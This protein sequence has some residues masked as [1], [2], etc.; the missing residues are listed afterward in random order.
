MTPNKCMEHVDSVKPNAY[1]EEDKL[2]WISE[3][4]GLVTRIVVQET[5]YDPYQYPDD[6]DTELL[7]PP[8][9]DVVYQL[10]LEAMIDFH[11][12]EYG[13]Y[14]NVM[15]MF[16]EKLDEYKKAYIREHMPESAGNYTMG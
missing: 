10:Y 11:N 2:A 12:R 16:N 15:L 14:N 5:Q 8:P 13:P 1:G 4:D 9:F 7:V 6:M 3:L